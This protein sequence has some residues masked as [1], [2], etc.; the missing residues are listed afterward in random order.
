MCSWW[1]PGRVASG[2]P[3]RSKWL[4]WRDYTNNDLCLDLKFCDEQQLMMGGMAASV[5]VHFLTLN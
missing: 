4:I 1:C 3:F 2:D 5:V